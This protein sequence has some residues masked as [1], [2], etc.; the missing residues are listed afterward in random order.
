MDEP[1][2]ENPFT[3]LFAKLFDET[4]TRKYSFKSVEEHNRINA[5]SQAR[6]NAHLSGEFQAYMQG[7]PID[8]MPEYEIPKFEIPIASTSTSAIKSHCEVLGLNPADR[9]NEDAIISAYKRIM[10]T[11]HPD[12]GGSHDMV[13]KLNEARDF[14]VR[15]I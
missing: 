12:K 4:N 8:E 13:L 15:H 14:L 11:A 10:R 5:A 6:L 2:S 1:N 3:K 9:L 7:K